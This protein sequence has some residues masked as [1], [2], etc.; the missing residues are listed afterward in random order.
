MTKSNKKLYYKYFDLYRISS[1][2]QDTFVQARSS[3]NLCIINSFFNIE[4]IIQSEKTL[5]NMGF[6][7]LTVSEIVEY[8]NTGDIHYVS[9]YKAKI[10]EWILVLILPNFMD[11]Q[12]ISTI[13]K[14]NRIDSK[15]QLQTYFSSDHAIN[16]IGKDYA[17]L[18]SY[19]IQNIDGEKFPI[20]YRNFY[21]SCDS[22]ILTVNGCSIKG[23]FHNHTLYSDG[24]CTISELRFLAIKGNREYIGISDHTQKVGG[25]GE[26]DII[27]QHDEIDKQNSQEDLHILKSLECEILPNGHLDMSENILKK[28]DYI[29]AAVHSDLY[30]TKKQANKRVLKAIENPYTKILAHPSARL[31]RRNIG[32]YLDMPMIIDACLRNN[33]AIEI[34]GDADRLDLDPQYI[35]YAIRKGVMFT[36]DSDTHSNNGFKSINNAIKI[37]EECHVPCECILNTY[38]YSMLNEL[39][40]KI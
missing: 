27:L 17:D 40:S 18:Y 8:K 38:S 32:L 23:N 1:F 33:V 30:M 24:E 16:L 21:T 35:D 37:A 9:M 12:L 20:K 26:K 13:L 29:I 11:V 34:N 15:K 31:F 22:L 28:C 4:I 10:P 36:I 19:F 6:D 39:W 2:L 3:Q 14:N 5:S 25:I 7:P